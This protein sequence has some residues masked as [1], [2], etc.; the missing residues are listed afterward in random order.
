MG[1]IAKGIPQAAPALRHARRLMNLPWEA[2]RTATGAPVRAALKGMG[3]VPGITN[4][5]FGQW[6]KGLNWLPESGNAIEASQASKVEQAAAAKSPVLRKL[7]AI[8][9]P[10][11][12]AEQAKPLSA[13]ATKFMQQAEAIG[14]EANEAPKALEVAKAACKSG[15]VPVQ[16]ASKS[17]KIVTFIRGAGGTLRSVGRIVG[18]L[19]TAISVG[20]N[21]YHAG[22]LANA[23]YQDGLSG[24]NQESATMADE[25]ADEIRTILSGGHGLMTPLSAVGVVFNPVKNVNLIVQGAK[26]TA[27]TGAEVAQQTGRNYTAGQEVMQKQL[28]P[29]PTG[30][31]GSEISNNKQYAQIDYTNPYSIPI[32]GLGAAGQGVEAGLDWA[33]IKGES[34]AIQ[35]KSYELDAKQM[36][37]LKQQVDAIAQR[38]QA[39]TP[40]SAADVDLRNRYAKLQG[41]TAYQRINEGKGALTRAQ[42]DFL[43]ERPA[44]PGVEDV[45]LPGQSWSVKRMATPSEI[46]HGNFS[47]NPF[48]W[49][50]ME[51]A[52]ADQFPSLGGLA[53][54]VLSRLH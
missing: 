6:T 33:T 31:N 43:L 29:N 8:K 51:K 5:R 25:Q 47:L 14:V 3:A 9:D 20:E 38:E 37:N 18:P 41:M 22:R 24:L 17:G 45:H 1:Q 28:G 16:L 4:T 39:G 2:M 10:A 26:Q 12:A 32:Q 48:K 36:A 19:G 11:R 15:E 44:I 34:S 21:V 54:T 46:L 30:Y 40:P 53:S 35:D 50:G 52:E 49:R 42:E 7:L 13:G 27:E 23:A